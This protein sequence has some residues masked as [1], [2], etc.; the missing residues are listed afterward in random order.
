MS[1]DVTDLLSM[2]EEEIQDEFEQT[3]TRLS[4][5][6]YVENVQENPYKMTRTA[7]QYIRDTILH[8][9]KS[10]IRDCGKTLTRYHI[11]DD[12]FFNGEKKLVGQERPVSTLFQHID[13]CA[14]QEE[15]ESIFVLIGPPGTGKSR[16]FYLIE[17]GLDEY[18]R[19]E[20]G[21]I[22]TYNWLF[23]EKFET[24]ESSE[25]G[26]AQNIDQLQEEKQSYAHLPESDIYSRT[27]CPLR[28]NPISLIPRPQREKL[29]RTVLEQKKEQVKQEISDPEQRERE[30]EKLDHF[31]IPRKIREIEPCRNCQ[32]IRERLLKLYDGDWRKMI[33]HIE[34]V[35]F[36]FS[37]ERGCGIA[38]VDPG[39][40]VETN[41]QPISKDQNKAMVS[42]MLKG[43]SLF[44]FYGKPACAA[45]GMIN[46]QDIFNKNHKQLQHLLSTIEEKTVD[47]GD[48]THKVDYAIFGSTNLPELELLEENV[49]TEGLRDRV[50]EIDVPYLLN[51]SKER[52]IY[53]PN[54]EEIRKKQHISPH[55]IT[56]GALY[57]VLS[58][59][60]PVDMEDYFQ[61]QKEQLQQLED[62]SSSRYEKQKERFDKQQEAVEE[63]DLE[64]KARIYNNDFS[65]IP[66]HLK[67]AFTDDF[68]RAIREEHINEEGKEGHSPR[69]FKRILGELARSTSSR[70]INPFQLYETIKS[71]EEDPEIAEKRLKLVK[72][73][74]H[75]RVLSEVEEALFDVAEEDI[76]E[77]V[78]KYLTHLKAHLR[79]EKVTD[80]VQDTKVDPEPYLK[81]EEEFIGLDE[82]DRDIKRFRESILQKFAGAAGPSTPRPEPEQALPGLVQRFKQAIYSERKSDFR[83]DPFVTALSTLDLPE[84]QL[85]SS[86]DP[87]AL[88]ED[89]NYMKD[90]YRTLNRL[91]TKS[92]E[93]MKERGL[94]ERAGY[95]NDCGRKVLHYVLTTKTTR[96]RFME[97][98]PEDIQN[99]QE[100]DTSADDAAD[101]SSKSDDDQNED[102]D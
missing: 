47:F 40:N 3:Y 66:P 17:K 15:D 29:L 28:D 38:E 1:E 56:I 14:K 53:R 41:L 54:V 88:P 16:I 35:P 73:N 33:K 60:E 58:R 98:S 89:Q 30:L 77:R 84:D 94:Q 5:P 63:M 2:L 48:V 69:W 51:Y 91:R 49:M 6:E 87:S 37:L 45:R 22:Y 68:V 86:L 71:H 50:E 19:T 101:D 43:I 39:V 34:V 27:A 100:D 99:N 62:H 13:A 9:G 52:E 12:P 61:T 93:R 97:V 102:D 7:Y 46:Y 92:Q 8:F 72:K 79:N 82:E 32:N 36:Q 42:S 80:P 95:C 20:E 90:V 67:S 81:Q 64:Q 83:L 44:E 85:F 57:T 75:N 55:T 59:L 96:N 70:C 26:F 76:I 24:Q 21:R 10:E 74:Y 4:Y 78:E 11:F 65:T 23:R 25:L 31:L 18:S